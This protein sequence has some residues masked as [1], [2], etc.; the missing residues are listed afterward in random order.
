MNLILVVGLKGHNDF[1]F[2]CPLLL[3]DYRSNRSLTRESAQDV[4]NEPPPTTH[5]SLAAASS[6][7]STLHLAKPSTSLANSGC[8]QRFAFCYSKLVAFLHAFRVAIFGTPHYCNRSDAFSSSL[9]VVVTKS[10]MTGSELNSPVMKNAPPILLLGSKYTCVKNP[11]PKPFIWK[12]S[13]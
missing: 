12:I 13:R 4:M 1:F 9:Q 3:L 2:L 5:P 10:P 8:E 11:V 6:A 7:A